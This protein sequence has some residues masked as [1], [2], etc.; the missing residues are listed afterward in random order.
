[1]GTR[2]RGGPERP[3][4][5]S[6][7]RIDSLLCAA[8]EQ[9]ASGDE[10]PHFLG[11]PAHSAA[12]WLALVISLRPLHR[13]QGHGGSRSPWP[14]TAGFTCS[15]LVSPPAHKQ[16]DRK[17]EKK[18]KLNSQHF[19]HSRCQPR[20]LIGEMWAQNILASSQSVM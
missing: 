18:V 14:S 20:A 2:A 11:S 4:L 10:I 15:L 9:F 19:A 12:A 5:A 1:M 6:L 8:K 13:A 17:K 16:R 7:F 3:L